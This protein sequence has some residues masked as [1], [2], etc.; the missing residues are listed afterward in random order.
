MDFF[1]P[2]AV[3]KAIFDLFLQHLCAIHWQFATF[4]YIVGPVVTVF[5]A[6]PYS[7]LA[8][9]LL[10]WQ[11]WQGSAL[12]TAVLSLVLL[13]LSVL[14]VFCLNHFV[15]KPT[16]SCLKKPWLINTVCAAMWGISLS[17]TQGYYLWNSRLGKT[18]N[19]VFL[20]YCL[21]RLWS[22]VVYVCSQPPSISCGFSYLKLSKYKSDSF[23]D[24]LF[25]FTSCNKYRGV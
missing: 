8:G 6:N 10:F 4:T 9:L 12:W 17:V 20:L 1:M 22:V 13:A 7:R 11:C 25:V 3:C 23:Q 18:F 15:Y 21:L 16:A 24:M 19:R 2:L 5:L 14:I